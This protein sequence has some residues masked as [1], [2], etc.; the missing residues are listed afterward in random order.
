MRSTVQMTGLP[1]S[2]VKRFRRIPWNGLAGIS[3]LLFLVTAAGWFESYWVGDCF[4]FTT[5]RQTGSPVVRGRR[6]MPNAPSLGG[7]RIPAGIGENPKIFLLTP[8]VDIRI[9]LGMTNPESTGGDLLPAGPVGAGQAP[10]P[11]AARHW[12]ERDWAKRENEEFGF[13]LYAELTAKQKLALEALSGGTSV[14]EAARVAGVSRATVF[15]WLRLC[16]PFYRLL[17]VAQQRSLISARNT[18]ISLSD[19]AANVLRQKLKEND[20]K[21]A[22]AVL[23]SGGLTEPR[24]VGRARA[25]KTKRKPSMS[26]AAAIEVLFPKP[27]KP[28]RDNP[29][30]WRTIAAEVD[31]AMESAQRPVAAL[32]A[33]PP[34]A[35]APT[36]PTSAMPAPVA[37]APVGPTPATPAPLVA[38]PAAFAQTSG[39]VS[40]SSAT[41]APAAPATPPVAEPMTIKCTACGV[42]VRTS[43]NCPRCG[44]RLISAHA[45]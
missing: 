21:A 34:V 26:G 13:M 25:G 33:P 36:G 6:L 45:H 9:M 20:L 37:P 3:A 41:Y 15:N 43:K 8:L 32:A 10:V 38:S 39:A 2:R 7:K 22:L 24:S 5:R 40:A 12:M 19:Y 23:K 4:E 16:E 30:R 28:A 31:Q 27:S 44:L 14:A 18:L 35:P 29:A 11:A 1:V 42:Y 17:A